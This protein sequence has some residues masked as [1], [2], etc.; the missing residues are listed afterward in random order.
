MGSLTPMRSINLIVIHCSASPNGVSLFDGSL[1]MPGFRTPVETID[2]WHRQRG[3]RRDFGAKGRFNPQ[4]TSIGYHFLIYT[5]GVVVTGRAPEE[6]GAHAQGHNANS[7]GLCMIGTDKFL[8]EQWE[9][10]AGW[11]RI[12]QKAYP[13]ARI[14]GHRDLS[15]DL[16]G[17]GVIS[18]SEWTKRCPGF[19]VAAWMAGGMVP[20]VSGIWRHE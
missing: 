15:P 11:V 19:D 8:P 3:F 6:V 14:V 7:I 4:L 10:L 17:D 5:S 9:A 2:Q 12:M 20:P 18:S 16:N 1:G 13:G